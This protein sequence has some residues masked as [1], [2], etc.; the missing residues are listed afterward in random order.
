M[1]VDQAVRD[2]AK[3]K[4]YE[5]WLGSDNSFYASYGSDSSSAAIGS[6]ARQALDRAYHGQN[7]DHHSICSEELDNNVIPM[8]LTKPD[9]KAPK[10]EKKPR[11]AQVAKPKPEPVNRALNGVQYAIRSEWMLSGKQ[12]AWQ[13]I[14]AAIGAKG[15]ESTEQSINALLSGSKH[16]FL[17]MKNLLDTK[18]MTMEELVSLITE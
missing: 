8:T 12:V 13:E 9:E 2:L 10:P 15:F 5:V 17:V 7:P 18:Q 11:Q 16:T 1:K 14:Q 3:K 6:T 4:G